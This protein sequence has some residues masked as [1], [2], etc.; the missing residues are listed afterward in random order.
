MKKLYILIF[1]IILFTT[2]IFSQIGTVC[3]WNDDKKAAVVLTFDDWSP[4]QYSI[5]VPELKKRNINGT[6]FIILSSVEPWNHPWS[7]VIKTADYGNEIGNHTQ[8]HPDLSKISAARLDS[9]IRSMKDTLDKHV[10]SQTVV[11][12]AYPLGAYNDQVLKEV[13]E[14]GHI[15]ARSVFSVS[16]NYTYNF[17]PKEN[18][19]F[20]ILTYQ[21]DGSRSTSDFFQQIKNIINGGGLLTYLYHSLDNAQGTYND[22]WF[23]KVLQD[24]LQKQ[25]DTLVS[26][27]NK[28]WITTLGKAIKYHREATCAKIIEEIPYNGQQWVVNLTDTLS[29]NGLY[30]QPLSIKLKTNGVKYLEIAQ[31][32]QA[33]K[34]DSVFNDTLLFH[35]VPNAGQIILKNTKKATITNLIPKEKIRIYP[36]PATNFI[37]IDANFSLY[38]AKIIISDL[39]GR[40]IKSTKNR[41]YSNQLTIDTSHLKRGEYV[42]NIS[43]NDEY[44][45]QKILLK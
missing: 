1:L 33:L 8:T 42:L 17:A 45:A 2:P 30:N 26:V 32:N 23:A 12:L 9:E 19:Y 37:T 3:K 15:A 18:D 6:F 44:Y 14:S 43:L 20:Q 27:R 16:Q 39:A 31:N 22:N 13:K 11:S 28:V 5:A 35:A 38:N 36:V 40:K 24:S 7:E 41:E 34:I 25:L 21:M 10:T 4:G 29:N